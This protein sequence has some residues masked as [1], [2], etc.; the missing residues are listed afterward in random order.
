[1]TELR[2][3]AVQRWF[4]QRPAA[5]RAMLC[6][7]KLLTI[8]VYLAYL[9]MLAALVLTRDGRLWRAV[10]VPAVVFLSGSVLRAVINA[11]RPYEVYRT[12]ALVN[13]DRSGQSFPSRHMFSAAVLA[14]CGLWLCPPLGVALGVI[15]L[16]MAPIRVLCG[17]HFVRDVVAG[18]LFGGV[19][20]WIGFWIV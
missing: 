1:M 3:H 16:L 19:A 8:I 9:V 20:G 17:V 18:V 10:L 5:L 13:K 7:N 11:P 6:A 14:M 12:P 4:C 15:V 2:Y